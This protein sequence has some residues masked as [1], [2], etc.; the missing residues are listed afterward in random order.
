MN[1]S[2]TLDDWTIADLL[3][4]MKVT[5][6][7]GSLVIEGALGGAIHFQAGRV[8]AAELAQGPS[9]DEAASDEERRTA[10]TDALYVLFSSAAGAFQVRDLSRP[11][12]HGWAVDEL[13]AEMNRLTGL[14][15]EIGEAG[16]LDHPVMLA[17]SIPAPVTVMP[18]DWWALASLIST[19]SLSQLEAE[20]GRGRAIRLLH[21]LWRLGIA[22]K[23][24]EGFDLAEAALPD[25]VEAEAGDPVPQPENEFWLD[26]LAAEIDDR[27][28]R[29][30]DPAEVAASRKEVTGV[31]APASTT[32]VGPILDE[33]RRLRGA[34]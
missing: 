1:L 7:T 19:F 4:I 27:I 25:S 17:G 13:V 23:V 3:Q 21:V 2:G 30:G 20:L 29:V 15:S 8:V 31:A 11:E 26:A 24:E 14:G 22:E 16:L 18:E 12:H 5:Q 28:P 34:R 6:K 32:L 33:M 9:L 10:S